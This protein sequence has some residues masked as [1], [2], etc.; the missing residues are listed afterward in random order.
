MSDFE[1]KFGSLS[2]VYG[3]ATLQK[4]RHFHICVV[5]MGGVGS[6]AAEALARSGVG[7]ITLVD[8]DT[9]S[10]SNI[11]RQIHTLDST[12]G[13]VKVDVVR[14][15]IMDIN[16]ECEIQVINQYLEDDSLRD[17]LERGYDGVIDAIDSIKYKS[18]MIYC[19]KRNKIPIVATGGAGGLIDPT[20]I[21]VKDLSR[22]W[23]DPLASAVRLCLRQV[24]SFSRDPKRSFG[25][26]CVYS[27]EQQR[28][29]DKDGNVGYQKPGVAKLS[30]D[31]AY[32]Y[33]SSV[34]VTAC[35]G[36]TAAA[37]MIEVLLKKKN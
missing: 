23:N 14:D 5:G 37:Q 25:V 8:G 26:P 31:C 16:A 28:Y 3:D 29:P 36:F 4:I 13:K 32:G 10:A 34:M 12:I 20:M 35:F 17:I 11:N 33:G 30:L 24:H 18:A 2:R 19:C 6:W 9:I 15:R 21:E 7:K 27:T 1:E 22:T